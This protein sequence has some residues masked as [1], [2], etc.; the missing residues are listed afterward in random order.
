MTKFRRFVGSSVAILVVVSGSEGAADIVQ[1]IDP[2][3]LPPT[4]AVDA[5]A[6]ERLF[7]NWGGLQDDLIRQGIGIRIDALT[8]FAGNIS[9]GTRQGATFASQASFNADINWERLADVT[10]LSTHLTV[11]NRSGSSVS[12]QFGD[13]LLPVQEIYGAGGDVAFHLVSVFAQETLFDRTLDVAAGRMN[14]ENDFASSPLYCNFLNNALCGDPK[15]LPGGDI[16]HSA[17]PEGVWAARVRVRPA[18]E[19]YVATGIYEVNRGLYGDKYFRSGFRFDTSQDSGVY[20]PI[21][22]EWV[23]EFGP[24]GLLGHYKIGFGYDTSAGYEDFTN[25]LAMKGVPGYQ[26]HSHAGNAQFWVLADQML[27]RNGPTDDAGLMGLAGIVKNDPNNTVYADQ[28]FVGLV[29]RGFWKARPQDGVSFLFTYVGVS[30]RLA[31][32]QAV[33]QSLGLTFSN[34]A[35]GIQSHEMVL[36]A[37]YRIHVTDGVRIRPDFQYVIRPNAQSNLRDAAVFGFRAYVDF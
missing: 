27:V 6:F 8:E 13:N 5:P 15:S 19:I 2:A 11:V 35:T 37:N 4:Q 22:I 25:A 29:D 20:L 1:A 24:D 31:K 14:V 16:G 23:P 9:G 7:G 18:P 10:G 3:T 36:E 30:D 33:E 21:E 17:Y 28:Y 26:L 34:G 12:R 32:V